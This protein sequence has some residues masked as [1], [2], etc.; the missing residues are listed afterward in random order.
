MMKRN[1]EWTLNP[2][3]MLDWANVWQNSFKERGKGPFN[4]GQKSHYGS[5]LRTE[6][7]LRVYET[8]FFDSWSLIVQ[9]KAG[10]VNAQAFGVGKVHAFLVGSPNAFTVETLSSNQN[11]GVAEFEMVF[12][13]CNTRYPTSTIF[14]QGEF[15]SKFQSQQVSLEFSW[16]Y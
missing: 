16:N 2:F 5:L 6:A 9:E 15:G 13:P 7:S 8:F 12:A 10:Y 1:V 4:V 3:V 14:W 11:L